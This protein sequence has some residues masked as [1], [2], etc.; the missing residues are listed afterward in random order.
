M[1]LSAREKL[2]AGIVG[3]V[4]FLLLNTV[5]LNAIMKKQRFLRLEAGA[6]GVELAAMRELLGE[7]ELWAARNAWLNEK[8]PRLENESSASVNLLNRITD[9]A[10]KHNVTLDPPPAIGQPAKAPFYQSV[11]VT[12]ETRSSWASLINFLQALQGPEQFIV[13]ENASVQ[14][15][16]GDASSMRGRFKVSRW[17][18]P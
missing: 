11:S 7:R 1:K 10:K 13:L 5:L 16:A 18:A 17:Y 2:L 4:A 14:I 9:L 8:Q 3:G 15:D 12:I 6:R